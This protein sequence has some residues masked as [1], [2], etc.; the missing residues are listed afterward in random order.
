MGVR[1][2]DYPLM[3]LLILVF[4]INNELKDLQNIKL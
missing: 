1:T 3:R 2:M 4:D